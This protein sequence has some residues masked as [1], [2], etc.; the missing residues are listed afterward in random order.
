MHPKVHSPGFLNLVNAAKERVQ[1]I[2]IDQYKEMVA[3][4]TSHTLIDVREDNEWQAGHV[5]GATHS[6]RASSSVTSKPDSPT[7]RR[8][9]SSIAAVGIARRS[10]PIRSARWATLPQFPWMAVGEPCSRLGCH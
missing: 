10:P 4:G 7:K 6:A 2:N 9:S 5:Q 3:N 8:H 1:E